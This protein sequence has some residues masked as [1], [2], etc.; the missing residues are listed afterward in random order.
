M[1]GGEEVAAGSSTQVRRTPLA[2]PPPAGGVPELAGWE[3]LSIKQESLVPQDV[4]SVCVPP[5]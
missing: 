3:G 2:C 1:E 4:L 5:Q